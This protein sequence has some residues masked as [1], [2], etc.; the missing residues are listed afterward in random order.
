MDAATAAS[1]LW[2]EGTASAETLT[3]DVG[4]DVLTGGLGDDSLVGGART[5]TARFSGT[6]AASTVYSDGA[7]GYIVSGTDGFDRLQGVERLAFSDQTVT[8]ASAATALWLTGT[9]SA[10]T[11]TG[12]TGDDVLT[13][14]LGD[15]SLVGGAGTDT[16]RFSGTLAASTVYSDGA[17]GYIV[18]GTD[19]FDRLQGV[20]RLAFSDQTVDAATAATA[21]WLEGT[22]SAETL[23]G[24]VGDDVLTGGLGDDSL[25]GGA[26]SDT[27]RFS[28][29]LAG[30]TVYSDGAG[31]FIVSGTDGFDRLQGVE[32]LAFSDQTVTTASAATAL[33]LQGTAS[34]ETLT[35][36]TGDDVLTGGLGDDTLIGGAGDDVAVFAGLASGYEVSQDAASGDYRVVRSADGTVATLHDIE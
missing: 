29:T 12:G 34:A 7:G 28:G 1:A 11:L 30:S 14:G 15:D 19:G 17:G 25:I 4:D 35:G 21:L 9:A 33:W 26:G 2:L 32:R 3:G 36:G 5:D 22:A 23:T 13:G 31:G 6:L 18:S 27:A 20:E 8:A 10:E 16:A 24:D